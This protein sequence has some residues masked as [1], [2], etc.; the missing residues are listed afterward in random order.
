MDTGDYCRDP[1]F[2]AGVVMKHFVAGFLF[3]IV[4]AW[5]TDSAAAVSP[6]HVVRQSSYNISSIPY[7][8]QWI[9]TASG[10]AANS[11]QYITRA[12][13]VP[14]AVVGAGTRAFLLS[15]GGLALT[16]A[17]IAAGYVIDEITGEVTAP[18]GGTVT[19][20]YYFWYQTPFDS[21]TH[22]GETA[23]VAANKSY[24]A[25]AAY[26]GG[27][28]NYQNISCP[29]GLVTQN[30]SATKYI[31]STPD[32]GASLQMNY[33]TGT[34]EYE[35]GSQTLTD[36][37]LGQYVADN[38]PE[39]LPDVLTDPI[40]GTPYEYQELTDQMSDVESDFNAQYDTDPAT[41]PDTDPAT[42]D[43]GLEEQGDDLIDCDLL[44]TLCD[45][46][47]WFMDDG[48]EPP[49][50]PADLSGFITEHDVSEYDFSSAAPVSLGG[51]GSCP[52]D[53]TLSI[54]NSTI[55]F[56]W[57]P[58]CDTVTSL[59]PWFLMMVSLSGLFAFTRAAS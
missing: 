36:Q 29:G 56:S 30:C 22:T 32:G 59:R 5:V 50:E 19:Q 26:Q 3:M 6:L 18:G 41:V 48:G 57:Q 27:G 28:T 39:Y 51:S 44:P 14:S 46:I 4:T 53:E 33:A 45:F 1:F 47:D 12:V 25:W 52:A 23:L 58:I 35:Q 17:L 31:G 21:V 2:L 34:Y 11:A 13:A 54:M 16:A 37:E 38:Y 49:L 10:V 15:P 43:D 20:G 7:K 55:D 42:Q 24:E 8:M 9:P 40:T